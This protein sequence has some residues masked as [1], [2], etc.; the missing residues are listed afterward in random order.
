MTAHAPPLCVGCGMPF[1]SPDFDPRCSSCAESGTGPEPIVAAAFERLF[2]RVPEQDDLHR[3]NC[4]MA[5]SVGHMQC[6]V[7]VEHDQPRF[8]CGCIARPHVEG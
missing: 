3:V 8:I 6:G 7:C 1:V 5:G 4:S 2:G